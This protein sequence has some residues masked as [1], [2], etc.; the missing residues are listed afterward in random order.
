M[1]KK[2]YAMIFFF[3]LLVKKKKKQTNL[4]PLLYYVHW[5]TPEIKSS[6]TSESFLYPM[7]PNLPPI[8]AAASSLSEVG[9]SRPIMQIFWMH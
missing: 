1:W 2:T 6:A 9:F 4:L 5:S 7:F 8:A 3:F